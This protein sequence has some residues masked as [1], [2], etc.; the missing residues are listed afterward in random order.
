MSYA[1][2]RLRGG[3]RPLIALDAGALR[4]LRRANRVQSAAILVSMVALAA[5]TGLL[6][7]GPEGLLAGAVL[8]SLFL[9]T[10]AG[11]GDDFFA[12]AYGAIR[13]TPSLAPELVRIAA[14]LAARAGLPRAPAL[15]IVPSGVLQAMVAG[16]RDAPAIAVTS[17]LLHALPAPEVAAVLAHEIAHIRHGDNFIMRL[18]AA[19]GVMTHAMATTGLFLLFAYL[20]LLRAT[21]ETVPMAAILIL[22]AAP[23][24]SD[25]LQ[26]SLSRRREFLAD[27][28]AVEL[29]G[30]PLALARALERIQALQGDD[31][32]RFSSRGWRWLH[33]LR[34]HPTTQERIEHLA[35]LVVPVRPVAL[36]FGPWYGP[37]PDFGPLGKNGWPQRLVRRLMP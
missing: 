1:P 6:I 19:A 4:R 28:G 30:D 15:H 23:F 18:A 10:A 34:T 33:W 27:A 3:T 36:P 24:V 11:A 13:A 2:R 31:W 25:L 12:R 32:E 22:L 37:L 5:L 9:V 29:T 17:G 20:P 35:K 21:G 14:A 7:A 16:G 26:L 8:S